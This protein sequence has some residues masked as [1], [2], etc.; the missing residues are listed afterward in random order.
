VA[1][2][3]GC[4]GRN[5]LSNFR[6]LSA[7][8]MRYPTLPPP[9][10]LHDELAAFIAEANRK[11][12]AFSA[13][14]RALADG[15]ADGSYAQSGGL[16]EPINAVTIGEMQSLIARAAARHSA[17]SDAQA[18]ARLE[19]ERVRIPKHTSAT[20]RERADAAAAPPVSSS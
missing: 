3:H 9:P 1:A 19:W 13:N 10:V 14:V 11:T 18:H 2:P 16:R 15:A 4:V 5:T 7:I 8:F 17:F 6:L 12:L 20:Q